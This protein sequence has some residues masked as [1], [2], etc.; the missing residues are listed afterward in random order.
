ML[1]FKTFLGKCHPLAEWLN[2][3]MLNNEFKHL[4]LANYKTINGSRPTRALHHFLIRPP[5]YK[6][7]LIRF[8]HTHSELGIHFDW[9]GKPYDKWLDRNAIEMIPTKLSH[10][11]M[12]IK[13]PWCHH[14]H[15]LQ[16]LWNLTRSHTLDGS[17]CFVLFFPPLFTSN[18]CTE[19]NIA[20][21][22]VKNGYKFIYIFKLADRKVHANQL[23]AIKYY[24]FNAL[25]TDLNRTEQKKRVAIASD[26]IEM[27]KQQ[28]AIHDH[29][30]GIIIDQWAT[31]KREQ[32][33]AFF[34]SH[35]WALSTKKAVFDL[36][37]WRFVTIYFTF[38]G[39]CVSDLDSFRRRLLLNYN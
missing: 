35:T 19:W 18:A 25:R 26:L 22:M 27:C 12:F 1:V 15:V 13:I 33:A 28:R 11:K 8:I 3:Q 36:L 24:E 6:L 2:H 17:V 5:K 37:K 31:A 10:M 30:S 7:K 14:K 32:T 29:I 16:R 20:N 9:M 23:E 34:P 4:N 38:V 21:Q 39:L